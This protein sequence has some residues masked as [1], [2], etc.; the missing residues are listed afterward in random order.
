[1]V[2]WWS[3]N[4]IFWLGVLLLVVAAIVDLVYSGR[5]TRE[6]RQAAFRGIPVWRKRLPAD[7]QAGRAGVSPTSESDEHTG[8]S[9][10]TR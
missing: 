10:I 2:A 3:A 1:M 9:A 5:R 7:R 6:E 8:I 4:G